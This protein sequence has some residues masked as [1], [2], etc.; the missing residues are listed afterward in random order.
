MITFEEWVK[1]QEGWR[2]GKHPKDG[3]PQ[4]QGYVGGNPRYGKGGNKDL[5]TVTN[6]KNNR[7]FQYGDEQNN[8]G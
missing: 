8:K 6:K 4:K 7:G 5:K 3:K 2:G 1:L